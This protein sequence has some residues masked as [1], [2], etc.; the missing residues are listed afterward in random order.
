MIFKHLCLVTFLVWFGPGIVCSCEKTGEPGKDSIV[1]AKDS[2][3]PF[4]VKPDLNYLKSYWVDSK[5]VISAPFHWKAGEWIAASAIAGSAIVLYTQDAAIQAFVLRNKGPNINSSLKIYLDP[6]GSGLYSLPTLGLL[7][8]A[9]SIWKNDKAK[10]TALKGLEAFIITEVSV[11][12]LKELTQRHRPYADDP[13]NPYLW[14]GPHELIPD[15]SFPSGHSACA[16]AVA[17]VIGSSYSKT[18]WVPIVCYSLASMTA[19]ARVVE[20]HHWASD[21]F[22]G[23]AIG[24]A[25]G[26]L[27]YHGGY[28]HL[29]ILPATTPAGQGISIILK[30]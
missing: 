8:G 22:I 23:S 20:N 30:L 26:R 28:R 10:S 17:T 16:F 21:A 2:V 7:Y 19:I 13:S 15:A 24:F 11:Q 14:N 5:A 25:V 6:F 29:R 12:L 1:H 3:E 9:G 27:V 4:T 18:I